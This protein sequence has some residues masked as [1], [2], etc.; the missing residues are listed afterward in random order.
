MR[1]LCSAGWLVEGDPWWDALQDAWFFAPHIDSIVRCLEASYAARDDRG[2]RTRAVRFAAAYD[3][4]TVTRT[5]WHSALGRLVGRHEP[6][7][8]VA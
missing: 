1:E 3:A 5:H 7:Q 2:M 8:L 6:S 4:D